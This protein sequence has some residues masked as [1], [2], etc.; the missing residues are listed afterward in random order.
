MRV[1][2]KGRINSKYIELLLVSTS[3]S[4][5]TTASTIYFSEPYAASSTTYYVTDY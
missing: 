5:G 4:S 3:I 1:R 2:E